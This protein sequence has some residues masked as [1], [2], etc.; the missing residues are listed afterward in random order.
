MKNINLYAIA[1]T[2]IALSSQSAH[3][4]QFSV[5][6]VS[7]QVITCNSALLREFKPGTCI[8]VP[9]N[10]LAITATLDTGEDASVLNELYLAVLHQGKYYKYDGKA[11]GRGNKWKAASA[12]EVANASEPSIVRAPFETD[13]VARYIA[14]GDMAG[15]KGAEMYVGV[16]TAS[17]MSAK[18]VFTLK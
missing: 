14:L 1:A 9:D 10:T 12:S 16:K 8:V 4:V 15:K 13:S 7:K 11:G 6:D 18:R 2:F 3:A 5:Q 17:G